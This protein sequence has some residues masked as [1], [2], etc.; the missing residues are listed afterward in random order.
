M[1]DAGKKKLLSAGIVR[2]KRQLKQQ[3]DFFIYDHISFKD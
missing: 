1:V 3:N 2:I